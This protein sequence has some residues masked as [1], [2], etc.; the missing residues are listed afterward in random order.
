MLRKDISGFLK[1]IAIRAAISFNRNLPENPLW[2]GTSFGST[3]SAGRSLVLIRISGGGAPAENRLPYT[4]NQCPLVKS[5]NIPE[6][7][8]VARTRRVGDSGFNLCSSRYSSP[9][10]HWTRSFR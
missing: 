4:A 10:T 9:A 1:P 6:L 8:Q 3:T 2:L 7:Q 5:R